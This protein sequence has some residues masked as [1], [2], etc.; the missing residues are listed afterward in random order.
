[1]QSFVQMLYDLVYNVS[2]HVDVDRLVLL[3]QNLISRHH[4]THLV[5]LIESVDPI[6]S[7]H[8]G[9]QY[10]SMLM[11]GIHQNVCGLGQLLR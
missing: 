9:R 6:C 1:M 3:K 8:M 4:S 7:D 5:R 10:E 11:V 2:G